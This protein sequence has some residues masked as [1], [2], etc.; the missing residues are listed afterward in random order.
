MVAAIIESAD[1]ANRDGKHTDAGSIRHVVDTKSTWPTLPASCSETIIESADTTGR[2]GKHT[3]AGSIRHVVDTKK[4]V[5]DAAS[6]VQ[7]RKRSE[8]TTPRMVRYGT[9]HVG[10]ETSRVRV[11]RVAWLCRVAEPSEV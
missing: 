10:T 1:E 6:V 3:D 11:A 9:S 4:H 8:Q 2:G 5:A 7:K